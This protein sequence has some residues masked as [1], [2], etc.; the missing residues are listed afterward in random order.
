M[1]M[2]N[3]RL[4]PSSLKSL[5]GDNPCEEEVS[6]GAPNSENVDVCKQKE[7]IHPQLVLTETSR[8]SKSSKPTSEHDAFA[9]VPK[10]P[11][12]DVCKVTKTVRAQCR[13][14][15]DAGNDHA[16]RSNSF[17]RCHFCRLQHYD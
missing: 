7:V 1:M 4:V 6:G 11:N 3:E 16:L 9:H 2:V 14:Q 17:C 15:L 13:R 5:I 10:D 12:C 8:R